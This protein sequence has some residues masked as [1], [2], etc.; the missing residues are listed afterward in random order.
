MA[1]SLAPPWIKTAVLDIVRDDCPAALSARKGKVVQVLYGNDSVRCVQVSDKE[2]SITVMLTQN[3]IDKL[4]QKDPEFTLSSCRNCIVKIETWHLS[5]IIQTA[6]DRDVARFRDLNISFPFALQCSKLI[7]LGA[8]DCTRIG[9]PEDINRDPG[10]RQLLARTNYLSL[11]EQLRAR[12]FPREASL[13][14]PTGIFST[15][16]LYSDECPL[17]WEHA[18]VPI[19]QFNQIH[20]KNNSNICSSP[21]KRSIEGLLVMTD[22]VADAGV[23]SDDEYSL[24]SLHDETMSNASVDAADTLVATQGELDEAPAQRML[25]RHGSSLLNRLVYDFRLLQTQTHSPMETWA[26]TLQETPDTVEPTQ[27]DTNHTIH[28]LSPPEFASEEEAGLF[29]SQQS[30][31][32]S[33]LTQA[34]DDQFIRDVELR[35]NG[36]PSIV[37]SAEN[38]CWTDVAEKAASPIQ[39]GAPRDASQQRAPESSMPDA[40]A[41]IK[42]LEDQL[43]GKTLVKRFRGFGVFLGKVTSR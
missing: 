10:V 36:T 25:W 42:V 5:T 16:Q 24:L 37:Q 26:N 15:P 40:D 30:Q 13:P 12:Q 23:P 1:K 22:G 17:L 38:E 34:L 32:Q 28:V 20:Q 14:D 31:G 3:C 29:T 2:R 35:L 11:V 27:V 19:D 18:V 4:H 21:E 33:W 39:S 9:D 6:G 7:M 41:S 8:T 43:I